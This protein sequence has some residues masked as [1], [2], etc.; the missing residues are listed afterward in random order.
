MLCFSMNSRIACRTGSPSSPILVDEGLKAFI[1]AAQLSRFDH[2][3][4]QP[5]PATVRSL[6][7]DVD[8]ALGLV[9]DLVDLDPRQLRFDGVGKLLEPQFILTA[10][11]R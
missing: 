8:L 5:R 9:A 10:S 2:R 11:G 4:L 1:V 3:S 6:A 7:N